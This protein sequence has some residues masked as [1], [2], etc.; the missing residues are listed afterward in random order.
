MEVEPGPHQGFNDIRSYSDSARHTRQDEI[1]DGVDRFEEQLAGA[2]KRW[3]ERTAA[4]QA[5]RSAEELARRAIRDQRNETLDFA[6]RAAALLT[7]AGIPS[8]QGLKDW[9]CAYDGW[10]LARSRRIGQ[11]TRRYV[12]VLSTDGKIQDLTWDEEWTTHREDEDGT[13]LDTTHHPERVVSVRQRSP[14]SDVERPISI[15]QQ[16]LF[17][18][19]VRVGFRGASIRKEEP[20]EL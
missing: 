8:E 12:L 19:L 1:I 4:T 13:I 9:G 16:L 5:E 17:D 11:P 15:V 18:F 10:V 14:E 6:V 3:H 2:T 7:R 20:T